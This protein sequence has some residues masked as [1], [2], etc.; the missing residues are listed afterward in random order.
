LKTG[1]RFKFMS[2]NAEYH[3]IDLGVR[4]PNETK[5][6]WLEAGEVGWVS[7][8]IRDAKEVSVGD[9]ITLV[10]NPTAEPLAGYKKM[11]PVVYTGFYPID[12]KD[13]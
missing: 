5:K 3:V 8:A 10:D 13:Y 11:K 7:A 1:D 2:N 6:E 12:T 4:N 9:T